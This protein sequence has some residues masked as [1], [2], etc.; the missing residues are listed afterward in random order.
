VLVS[1]QARYRAAILCS[2]VLAFGAVGAA[3]CGK[4]SSSGGLSADVTG[5]AAVPATAE[6]VL[7]IDVQRVVGS[8]L[9]D[10]AVDVLL[11]RDP[12][13]ADRWKQLHDTCKIDLKSFA[14]VMLAIGPH[15]GPQ[16]GTGPVLFIATGKLVETDLAACVRSM[17][18]TGSGGL[19][20]STHG[21][22]TLYQAKDGNRVMYFA[23]GRPDTVIMGAN[24]A[25][26]TEALG[27]GKKITDNPDFTKWLALVDQKAPIWAVGRVDE[28]VRQGLVK[29]TS[30]AVSA[31][32]TAMV[33]SIDPTAGV[34]I[35]LGAVMASPADA[36]ALESFAKTQL[37]ALGM[38]AQAKSLG[39]IV[40]QV[41]ITS[42]ASLV[43]FAANLDMTAV[44][45]LISVLDGGGGSAQS[46][47]PPDGSNGSGGP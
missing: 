44:N 10:H 35:E 14:H 20:A 3:G 42:D 17:V 30:G 47:P 2:L 41:K 15:P 4:K 38:V 39:T 16:P 43:R 5:L 45:Q 46:A 9:V 7:A 19:T 37:A 28:R 21:N 18:G 11:Q 24:E 6:V 33:A 40:D 13:L 29:V 26:V 25:A 32:P 12:N 31:G 36:K 34:K 22:R 23:F 1:P 8:P 27:G